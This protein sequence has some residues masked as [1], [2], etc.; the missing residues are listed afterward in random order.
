MTAAAL[1]DQQYKALFADLD[2]SFSSMDPMGKVFALW[3][4]KRQLKGFAYAHGLPT[5]V[6]FENVAKNGDELSRQLALE[7]LYRPDAAVDDRL[8]RLFHH[9]GDTSASL[10]LVWLI[11]QRK[12]SGCEDI[13]QALE[14]HP[15]DSVRKQAIIVRRQ[16][17]G[18]QPWRADFHH[19]RDE[20]SSVR[21]EAY[22]RLAAH[23]QDVPLFIWQQAYED[24]DTEIRKI[25]IQQLAKHSGDF[26]D[27]VMLDAITNKEFVI[28]KAAREYLKRDPD[29]FFDH[30]AGLLPDSRAQTTNFALDVLC[31]SKKPEVFDLL[32]Q[33]YDNA[34]SEDVRKKVMV[35]MQKNK[36]TESTRFFV[37]R[38]ELK[39]VESRNLKA[40]LSDLIRLSIAGKFGVLP[41]IVKHGKEDATAA[42]LTVF[43]GA[44]DGAF[45]KHEALKAYFQNGGELSESIKAYLVQAMTRDRG[46]DF[47]DVY[48]LAS[49]HNLTPL[50]ENFREFANKCTNQDQLRKVKKLL[51][52]FGEDLVSI[53]VEQAPLREILQGW[54]IEATKAALSR[55]TPQELQEHEKALQ[56]LMYHNNEDIRAL[57]RKCLLALND[58]GTRAWLGKDVARYTGERTAMAIAHAKAIGADGFIYPLTQRAYDKDPEVAALAQAALE[59]GRNSSANLALI[60]RNAELNRQIMIDTNACAAMSDEALL[61]LAHDEFCRT[62]KVAAKVL[63]QRGALTARDPEFAF[64]SILAEMFEQLHAC[65]TIHIESA[66]RKL[67]RY[68]FSLNYWGAFECLLFRDAEIQPLCLDLL[69]HGGAAQQEAAASVLKKVS[70]LDYQALINGPGRD[71]N[72][73]RLVMSALDAHLAQVKA[74]DLKDLYDLHLASFEFRKEEKDDGDYRNK[75]DGIAALL[76]TRQNIGCSLFLQDA[77]NFIEQQR[78]N[79]SWVSDTVIR[80][81]GKMD[82]KEP[83]FYLLSLLRKKEVV[84]ASRAL[85]DRINQIER[86]S[87]KL[88]VALFSRQPELFPAIRSELT[89][90]TSEEFSILL[91][92]AMDVTLDK[93]FLEMCEQIGPVFYRHALD[94][95]T[96]IPENTLTIFCDFFS[97]K[98]NKEAE[99]FLFHHLEVSTGSSK[100]KA[101]CIRGLGKIRCYQALSLVESRLTSNDKD[102]QRAAIDALAR[103]GN[104]ETI[105]KLKTVQPSLGKTLVAACEKAI[106]K[107]SKDMQKQN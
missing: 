54:D 51:K 12:I 100:K 102:I 47:D 34:K 45:V 107:I 18:P 14:S 44:K 90:I 21:Q 86:P 37:E 23:G 4:L 15:D 60:Q 81:I 10:Q 5:L 57:V 31:R 97:Q 98:A 29:R 8:L 9:S 91:Q 66:V 49:N 53:E 71:I 70:N 80:S 59:S 36:S 17:Y 25:A 62:G 43:E 69:L 75:K 52:Q 94:L 105:E 87:E 72:T 32:I 2:T 20:S 39:P 6:F 55:A 35:E 30:L 46:F 61:A 85:R 22:E 76:C 73:L 65:A 24:S 68:A 101:Y 63:L 104:A 84:L 7:L 106:D 78:I 58:E 38:G 48:I 56:N 92:A 88:I 1:V 16:L 33:T 99:A 83:L 67:S 13:L 42:L 74:S 64:L 28:A 93:L 41:L 50:I 103:I 95:S 96:P 40:F 82:S 27:A 89:T 77:I 19:T 79:Q 11:S 26:I 3:G